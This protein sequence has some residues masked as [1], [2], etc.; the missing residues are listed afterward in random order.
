MLEGEPRRVEE[1][2]LEAELACDPV[3]RIAGDGEVDRREMDADLVRPA[4]LEPDAQ[5]R[6]ALEELLELEVRHRRARRVACRASGGA[7]SCRSRPIGA[8][9][10]P[11]RER[12]LPT[13]SARYSR[14]SARRRTSRCS[15][16]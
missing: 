15:R 3:H 16:S 8:S 6:V 14:V 12:G 10:V 7:R 1:L 5:E 4:G 11:R 9:I 13:T 2:P